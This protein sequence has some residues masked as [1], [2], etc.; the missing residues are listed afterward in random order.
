MR[1]LKVTMTAF[2]PYKNREVIDFCELNDERVFLI[3]GNTGAGKTTIFDA[4]CFALYGEAS[5][6]DRKD[7]T[8]LRSHY[9]D[10]DTHASVELIFELKGATYK[11]FRQIPHVKEGNKTATGGR[12]ELYRLDK[13]QETPL[14]DRMIVTE[15]NKKLETLLGLTKDQFSQIVML[16]Q[17]EFRKL[18]T[19]ETEN[20]EAILR[21]IFRTEPYQWMIEQ[22][23][24]KRT[25]AKRLAEREGEA[26]GRLFDFI[27]KEVPE[28]DSSLL[29]EVFHRDYYNAQQIL[30]SLEA[31][32]D[33]Y[34][35][36]KENK[37]AAHQKAEALFTQQLEK[38]HVAETLHSR[39][40]SLEEKRKEKASL[41]DKQPTYQQLEGQLVKAEK[42][43]HIK[44]YEN[45]AI[46]A[47]KEYLQKEE[48]LK[49]AR[50]ALI[51]V[52]KQK[53]QAV[54]RYDEAKQEGQEREALTREKNRLEEW[55]P[56]VDQL[57]KTRKAL[58]VYELDVK[59]KSEELIEL[60]KRAQNTEKWL[61]QAA[62]E[63]Q[64]KET[65]TESASKE[66]RKLDELRAQARLLKQAISLSD[67]LKKQTA[68]HEEKKAMSKQ[69]K[70]RADR[71]EKIW[72]EGQASLL[73]QHL[74]DG[75]P[76]PVCGSLEHP[77][78]NVSSIQLPSK[79]E[80]EEVRI[81]YQEIEKAVNQLDGQLES[82]Q[83]QEK[84]LHQ[85]LQ[86]TGLY[87]SDL[88]EQLESLI[89]IGK[90]QS[91][92]VE[93]L[94][95]IQ[96]ELT[97]LKEDIEKRSSSLKEEKQQIEASQEEYTK[98]AT[99]FEREK[100]VFEET[101]KAIP[102]ALREWTAFQA[103]A[104]TV[105][106]QLTRLERK[107]EQA[108]TDFQKCQSNVTAQETRVE[109]AEQQASESEGKWK[110]AVLTFAEQRQKAGFVTED[111]YKKALYTEEDINRLKAELDNFKE[112][113]SRVTQQVN[114]L[115]IELK[116][117][118]PVDIEALRAACEMLKHEVNRLQ[119]EKDLAGQ[120]HKRII[121]FQKE[122]FET[123]ER[124]VQ[125]E[126]QL[127]LYEDLYQVIRG[128]NS[129][130]LSL[131]RFLQI[132]YL[133]Q[134]VQHANGRL[135]SLSNGQFYLIRS[136][137]IEK[138]NRPSGLGLDVYDAYT[139]Q[140]RDVKSLSG[141]EKFN[142]SLSLALGMSDVI[143]SYQGGVSIETMFID[144]GFGSLD[145]ESLNKAIDALFDLQKSGR[146]IG[147]ISHI[148]ELKTAIPAR[149]EIK[150][151]KE[152]HSQARFLVHA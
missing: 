100:A 119:T 146:M 19:S 26:L 61:E 72:V 106:D 57:E 14:V 136:E 115:E 17:G 131:E 12:Q 34:A 11:V 82:T 148:Q 130:Q 38:L 83:Q 78:K 1:P 39:F 20:K 145:E 40:K 133:E 30:E 102:E 32:S 31:E 13:D 128:S 116:N 53:D 124:L 70:E 45:Y 68:D 134:I 112:A 54:A 60:K 149:L 52:G 79:E 10:D 18:L 88:E 71:L 49:T 29:S 5:G 109:G 143:Q 113:L 138:N 6:E 46:E 121:Q 66:Q 76:C 42:A 77:N 44:V 94:K 97:V 139:G 81:A 99:Q 47:K 122:V 129:K 111:D 90:V 50:T 137:R 35:I 117:K 22:L 27:V 51:A 62:M 23:R 2:G 135:Q 33:Y 140:T 93:A 127:S 69:A 8:L 3:S 73:A 95:K 41:E 87:P 80:L 104:R 86:E 123:K 91:E 107:W 126:K 74:H 24:L 89:K 108:Q 125:L 58:T 120:L 98:K 105:T 110:K 65:E 142:A 144:E 16:P 101:L 103:H 21:R 55:T 9:A 141:G 85:D 48:A 96:E 67:S 15:V 64:K 36:E 132:E 37:S 147:V 59:K 4:I 92:H 114:D 43:T 63:R 152:G 28:R 84:G 151:N 150:K 56:K 118:Q 7:A 25:E 75:A